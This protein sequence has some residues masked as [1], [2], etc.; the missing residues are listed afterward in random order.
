[1]KPA[2]MLELA[3][4]AVLAAVQ[5]HNTEDLFLVTSSL[6]TRGRVM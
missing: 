2:Y 4:T 3:N 1:M 6:V 5:G